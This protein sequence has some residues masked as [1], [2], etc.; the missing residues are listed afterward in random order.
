MSKKPTNLENMTISER[1]PIPFNTYKRLEKKK[2]ATCQIKCG[3]ELGSGFFCQLKIDNKKKKFVFTSNHILKNELI[4]IGKKFTILWKEKEMEIKIT[5]DR[6]ICSNENLDYT[7][8]ELLETE[9]IGDN[10]FEIY[11]K[12]E[13]NEIISNDTFIGE[14]IGDI[15][16]PE[17]QLSIEFGK[18]I[19]FQD[20]L[21]V[22]SIPT[23]K[24]SSGS[25]LILINRDLSLIGIHQGSRNDEKLNNGISFIKILKDIKEQID[26][27]DSEKTGKELYVPPKKI[28]LN[29]SSFEP[30]ECV[31]DNGNRYDL[32]SWIKFTNAGSKWYFFRFFYFKSVNYCFNL[33]FY[34]I[35]S[36]V[37]SF[38]NYRDKGK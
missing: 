9:N 23:S 16:Y 15:Q 3:E 37:F 28:P 29:P 4:S 35:G 24:G 33:I 10:Y 27:I 18:I 14:E 6:I 5:N 38:I 21:I 30:Y 32:Y 11:H 19:R 25:P 20:S 2:D 22:H 13:N 34:I 12:I 7:C 17:N 31:E 1:G 8:V 36:L 26:Q